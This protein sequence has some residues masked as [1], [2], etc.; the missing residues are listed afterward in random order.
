MKLIGLPLALALGGCVLAYTMV[1]GQ[2]F[3]AAV[4]TGGT[5]SDPAVQIVAQAPAP[6]APTTTTTTANTTKVDETALRYF[7]RLGDTQRVDAEMARLRALYPDWVP[8]TNLLSDDYVPDAAVEHIWD[9]YNQGD[10]AGARAAIAEKQKADPAF[11]PSPDLL[12]S[13]DLGEASAR[14]R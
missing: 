12:H 10:F 13:L 1:N 4:A 7:A 3:D 9:L 2:S 14:L 6:A 8:P 5:P 11:V